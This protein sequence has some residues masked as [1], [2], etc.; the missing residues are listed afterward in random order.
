MAHSPL[1]AF[2]APILHLQLQTM[3]RPWRL[4]PHG[5]HPYP[6]GVHLA[7]GRELPF[8][9][10]APTS[11]Q[12]SLVLL[13]T[14]VPVAWRRAGVGAELSRQCDMRM[15]PQVLLIHLA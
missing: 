5:P 8:P 12:L 4:V 6:P 2:T 13:K 15:L 9:L 7:E 11:G 3:C 14:S 1:S 10:Q